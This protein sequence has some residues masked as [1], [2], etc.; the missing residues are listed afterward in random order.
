MALRRPSVNSPAWLCQDFLYHQEGAEQWRYVQVKWDGE[1]FDRVS[2][3][4][5]YSDPP[6]SDPEQRG[7]PIVAQVDYSIIGDAVTIEDWWVNWR[8]EFPLRVASNYLRNCLYPA[9][10]KYAVRVNKE[11]YAFWVSEQ[12]VPTTNSP[13]DFLYG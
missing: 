5:D 10:R 7:G 8:D 12:F 13:D 2:A 3:T 6:Y 1:V 9:A 4:F 11:A